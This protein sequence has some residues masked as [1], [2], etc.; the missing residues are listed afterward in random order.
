MMDELES[1]DPEIYL[2]DRTHAQGEIPGH[3]PCT[4]VE[5]S[6]AKKKP[7]ATAPHH[8]PWTRCQHDRER[9]IGEAKA[10]LPLHSLKVHRLQR[11]QLHFCPEGIEAI[12]DHLEGDDFGTARHAETRV[13]DQDLRPR[14]F[15]IT[16]HQAPRDVSS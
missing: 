14:F 13:D 3:L 8:P 5:K 12:V 6:Q 2:T 4:S 15:Q 7:G 1:F 10:G 11:K 16:K 9:P